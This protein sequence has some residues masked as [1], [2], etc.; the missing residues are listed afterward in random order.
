M[1]FWQT[2]QKSDAAVPRQQSYRLPRRYLARLR[3]SRAFQVPGQAAV[4]GAACHAMPSEQDKT[5]PAYP[6]NTEKNYL[7]GEYEHKGHIISEAIFFSFSI[8]LK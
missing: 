4:A 2:H 3:T 5:K 7:V 8:L 1:Y 6:V